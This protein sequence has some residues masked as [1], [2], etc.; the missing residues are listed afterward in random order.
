MILNRQSRLR[1]T[2]PRRQAVPECRLQL[3]CLEGREVPATFSVNTTL[4]DVT[5]ANGQMSLRE[6]ISHANTNPG[7]DTI[8]LSAGVFKISQ[9]GANENGNGGGDCDI[10]G[11]VTIPGAGA[12]L[13]IIDGQKIDRV[14][15]V[16]GAAPSSIKVVFAG[17]TIRN[18]KVSGDGGG[19]RV[20]NAD[21]VV[22]DCVVSG[23]LAS[24]NG[25]GG[26]IS[27]ATLPGTG[28]IKITRTTV[29]RNVATADGGGLAVLGSS[30]LTMNG[31][32][33]RR[34]V[35]ASSSGGIIAETATVTN[36]TISGNRAG[37]RVVAVFS[38]PH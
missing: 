35:S 28:N 2:L 4:D 9:I 8:V 31:S 22:R 25:S 36:S 16:L 29:V 17:L 11:T 34:N 19:I 12:G 13:T 26:G 7:A 37:V 6:A 15:D 38:R 30:V 18:G 5:P 21:L 10:T 20:S 23:N 1:D 27:N 14:F 32:T 3:E 24:A 33:V